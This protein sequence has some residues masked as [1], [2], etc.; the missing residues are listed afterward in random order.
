MI[1]KNIE[2]WSKKKC[3][4]VELTLDLLQLIFSLIIP[5]IIVAWKYDLFTK[6]E[7]WKLTSSGLIVVV[8]VAFTGINYLSKQIKKLPEATYNERKVKYTVQGIQKALVPAIIIGILQVI[9]KNVETGV[10]VITWCMA[11]Y[12]VAIA[13]QYL[14]TEY[15]SHELM[16]Y[17][18]AS[19]QQEIN[20]KLK[21]L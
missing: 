7:G 17:D 4:M 5:I 15:V 12:I 8:I 21:Q 19:E 14:F 6:A 18:K 10:F 16:V 11:S 3:K 13:I 20:N 1:F 2:N 9:K